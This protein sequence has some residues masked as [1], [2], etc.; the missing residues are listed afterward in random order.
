[1]ILDGSGAPG[2]QESGEPASVETEIRVSP[3]GSSDLEV[4]YN[5]SPR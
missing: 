4:I 1:M 2:R 3:D 5:G